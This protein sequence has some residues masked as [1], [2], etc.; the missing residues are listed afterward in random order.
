[1]KRFIR[2][3]NATGVVDIDPMMVSSICSDPTIGGFEHTCFVS[4]NGEDIFINESH[5][6]V[7]KAIE[8]AIAQD[9]AERLL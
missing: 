4:I 5:A 3:A 1:M 8:D 6:V 9:D 7:L 2:F